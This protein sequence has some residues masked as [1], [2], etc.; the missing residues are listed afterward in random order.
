MPVTTGRRNSLY[1]YVT[2]TGVVST[3]RAAASPGM[4]R[5]LAPLARTATGLLHSIS[6]P[7]AELPPTA[8]ALPPVLLTQLA[9]TPLGG[10]IGDHLGPSKQCHP[11]RAAAFG[12]VAVFWTKDSIN[13][14]ATRVPYAT[15]LVQLLLEMW[16]CYGQAL[17]HPIAGR[18]S[19]G[20][21][22]GEGREEKVGARTAKIERR[23]FAAL[24]AR[25]RS[26][27]G[28]RSHRADLVVCA[29][30]PH[31]PTQR[32]RWVLAEA[33]RTATRGVRSS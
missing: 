29:P 8:L 31:M 12:A 18:C 20:G 21:R 19:E 5:E 4:E 33:E 27:Q 1:T 25:Q 9:P 16:L 11:S 3:A 10:D 26:R 15:H 24:A 14:A 17:T 22:W 28:L 23:Q 13:H 6:A 2:P 7:Q 32:E 30:P